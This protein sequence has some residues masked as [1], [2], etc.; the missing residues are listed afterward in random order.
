MSY[1]SWWGGSFEICVKQL[2]ER[3]LRKSLRNAQLIYEE[4]GTALIQI[5]SV[6]NSRPLIYVYEDLNEPPLTTTDVFENYFEMHS[7]FMRS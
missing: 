4:L 1:S 6:L 7:L 3:C 5:E 2:T